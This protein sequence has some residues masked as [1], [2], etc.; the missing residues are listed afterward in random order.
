MSAHRRPKWVRAATAKVQKP[1]SGHAHGMRL[2]RQQ[3]SLN[4]FGDFVPDATPILCELPIAAG[5]PFYVLA[6]AVELEVEWCPGSAPCIPGDLAVRRHSILMGT[7]LEEFTEP[8]LGQF[9][10]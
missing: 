6:S 7:I 2:C 1:S 8:F 9:N 3:G 10:M 5:K 4:F